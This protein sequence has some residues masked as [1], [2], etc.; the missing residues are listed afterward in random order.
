MRTA[1]SPQPTRPGYKTLGRA[2][3]FVISRHH[4]REGPLVSRDAELHVRGT[5]IVARRRRYVVDT[6]FQSIAYLHPTDKR[7][8]GD[9]AEPRWVSLGARIVLSTA[10][11]EMVR[12]AGRCACRGTEAGRGASPRPLRLPR[13]VPSESNRP[14]VLFR[15][16]K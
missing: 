10:G 12:L 3:S 8:S 14:R 1:P 9:R 4:Y 6:R 5:S 16:L 2:L 11:F 13:G 7:G 15:F